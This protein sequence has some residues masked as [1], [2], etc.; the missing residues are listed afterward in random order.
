MAGLPEDGKSVVYD[1]RTG[2]KFDNRVTVG[3]MYYL[4]LHHL[5]DDKIHARSVGPYSLVTQQPLGG[6]AQF[7]GQRF[8]EMEV[9]ALEAYGAAYTLQEILTVKSDD[10]VGRV[11]AFESIVKGQNIPAPGIPEAFR[12]MVKELQSL[13]LDVKILDK[14][15]EEIDIKQ[16]YDEDENMPMAPDYFDEGAVAVDSELEDSYS[17]EGPDDEENGLYDGDDFDDEDDENADEDDGF[18]F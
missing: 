17:M 4:K 16:T 12:V 13:G 8:G 14:D 9:W 7:G 2:E 5:V 3:Y 1:G 11:K 10:V 15:N 18:D 6:K